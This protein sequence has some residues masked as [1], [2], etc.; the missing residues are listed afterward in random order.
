MRILVFGSMNR[1]LTFRVEHIAAPGETIAA[2][3]LDENPGGKGLNQALATARAG[4]DTVFAG[5]C[6]PDGE[7]LLSLL[8]E[9]G[10]DTAFVRRTASL[11]GQAVIQVAENGE[12]SVVLFHGANYE[13]TES[14][15]RRTLGA[16][17]PG[18]LLVLQNEI[19]GL[20]SLIRLGAEKGLRIVFN[21]SPC[22]E[23]ACRQDLSL[24]SYLLV[25]EG[26]ARALTG[27]SDP[28]AAAAFLRK[29]FPGLA[30]VITLGERGS[31]G[32]SSEGTVFQP[33]FPVRAVDT[34]G[35]GDT[36]TGYFLA[37]LAR[38]DALSD[39]LRLASAAA[40]LAVTKPGAASS[41]PTAEETARFLASQSPLS[42]ER[43]PV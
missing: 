39:A 33:A 30:G 3:R 4:A 31:L 18:D 36:F 38:G 27:I 6:G 14:D 40:A 1:D 13:V 41:I 12:N 20:E 23:A 25:N 11:T 2:A 5:C 32:F 7:G 35:A 37:A 24:L 26:E 21:P 8:G 42:S 9:N 43:S 28:E 34:T 15:I 17:A 10:V 16:F 19:S 29:R 22:D